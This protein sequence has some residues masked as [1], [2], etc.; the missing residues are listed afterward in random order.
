MGQVTDQ[1]VSC[2][3]RELTKLSI[4]K[5]MVDECLEEA[6]SELCV[7][8]RE[9]TTTTS[10][11]SCVVH[12]AQLAGHCAVCVCLNGDTHRNQYV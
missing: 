11:F 6:Q 5:S 4:E 2:R 10:W 12:P 8:D 7:R 9:L 1:C 3:D